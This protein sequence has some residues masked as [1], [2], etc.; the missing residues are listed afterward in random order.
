M[1]IVGI[2]LGLALATAAWAQDRNS[3]INL[4]DNP[5]LFVQPEEPAWPE[6]V[7]VQQIAPQEQQPAPSVE[8][9]ENVLEEI[10]PANERMNV[11]GREEDNQKQRLFDQWNAPGQT[12]GGTATVRVV[13]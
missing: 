2:A 1:R 3:P 4:N 8:I 10:P 12:K 5:K 11:G 9:R 6:S 13:E 7:P